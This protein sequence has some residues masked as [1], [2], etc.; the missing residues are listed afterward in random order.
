MKNVTKYPVKISPTRK[1]KKKKTV[2]KLVKKAKVL[3]PV[4]K[5]KKA[6]RLY[7]KVRGV[8]FAGGKKTYGRWSRR[9]R[10]IMK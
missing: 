5:F 2:V 3:L 4:R 9:K 8:K 6:K 10:V 7:V 1:F